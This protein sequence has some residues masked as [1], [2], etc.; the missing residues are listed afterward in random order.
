MTYHY[1]SG[2]YHKD[3]VLNF[4]F[5]LQPPNLLIA[6]HNPDNATNPLSFRE[7]YAR[8]LM[9][10][11]DRQLLDARFMVLPLA[12]DFLAIE[13][14]ERLVVELIERFIGAIFFDSFEYFMF[15]FVTVFGPV[16]SKLHL[17]RR[18]TQFLLLLF[19]GYSQKPIM[20]MFR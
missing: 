10:E 19:S 13:F 15:L 17:D 4:I 18:Q 1:Y 8:C 6:L 5:P 16:A 9:R 11:E 14:V 20:P 7:S 12:F 2:R 3:I